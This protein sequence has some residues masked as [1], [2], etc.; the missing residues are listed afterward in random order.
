MIK[1]RVRSLVEVNKEDL[2]E[3]PEG[4][5]SEETLNKEQP[6]SPIEEPSE[7]SSYRE[8]LNLKELE[9]VVKI[10][11]EFR[12]LNKRKN[13][14]EDK[15]IEEEFEIKMSEL[16]TKLKQELE[17]ADNKGMKAGCIIKIRNDILNITLKKMI[18]IC[19]DKEVSGLW[20]NIQKEL[21]EIVKDLLNLVKKISSKEKDVTPIKEEMQ[22]RV[23][24]LKYRFELERKELQEQIASLESENKKYLD[25]L[26]KRS[27]TLSVSNTLIERHSPNIDLS[28][29]EYK[30]KKKYVLL[31]L[32]HRVRMN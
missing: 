26:I 29:K 4:K 7:V 15:A 10:H 25:T 19:T 22:R 12:T 8:E 32:I 31:D 14:H 6:R 11:N 9:G 18:D 23:Q 27:K 2:E 21:N 30:E 5:L 13:P 20:L 3:S 28:Y 24:E 17:Q 16:A 1:V